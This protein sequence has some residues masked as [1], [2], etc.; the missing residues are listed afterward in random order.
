MKLNRGAAAVLTAIL[1]YFNLP[2]SYG[3]VVTEGPD[4][5]RVPVS[6]TLNVGKGFF[7]S[8]WDKPT[9]AALLSAVIPGAGQIYNK[10]YWKAPLVWA[11]GATIGYFIIDHN[12]NYQDFRQALIQRNRDSSDVYV[13][14][15]IYGIQ[16]QNGTLNLRYSRD[17]YRRNRDLTIMISVLAYGLNI[18]E[19]YVHAHLR[20][21]DVSDDLALKIQP[22]FLPIHNSKAALTPGITLVL[23]TKSK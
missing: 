20:E 1:L 9:K 5:L 17:F 22:D 15:P 18:A 14:D 8:K 10:A 3:Q 16:R 7:L 6:D 2:S 19:A 23:Y 11:T 12:K 4:S 13:N 21:F